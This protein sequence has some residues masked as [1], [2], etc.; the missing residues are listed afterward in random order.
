MKIKRLL[1]GM[2]AC[3]AMVA[4]TNDDVLENNENPLVNKGNSYL[5]VNLSMGNPVSRA[6]ETQGEDFD[7]G[8]KE[9]AAVK[10]NNVIFLFYDADGNYVTEGTIQY[11]SDG[12]TTPAAGSDLVWNVKSDGTNIERTY[13]PVIVLGPTKVAPA[14]VIAILNNNALA[15]ICKEKKL[16]ATQDLVTNTTNYRT[17]AGFVMSNSTYV[18]DNKVVYAADIAP[19]Q[20]CESAADA[21]ANPVDIYVERVAAKITWK[22]ADKVEGQK[23]KNMFLMHSGTATGDYMVNGNLTQL[24]VEIVGVKANAYNETSSLVKKINTGSYFTG[25]NNAGNFRSYW[26]EDKN[27]NGVV[28]A[29]LTEPWEYTGDS[30]TSLKYLTFDGN[31]NKDQNYGDEAALTF[32]VNENTMTEPKVAANDK[33]NA[34]TILVLGRIYV[35]K[36]A[37]TANTTL[38]TYKGGYYTED[39][40][41]DI[42]AGSLTDFATDAEG[43]TPLTAADFTWK[44]TNG[45]YSYNKVDYQTVALKP[46]TLVEG[47]TI[48]KKTTT[49]EGEETT[50]TWTAAT[51]ADVQNACSLETKLYLNGMCYYQIPIKHIYNDDTDADALGEYG[52]VRN[53]SYQLTL[54]KLTN[55]GGA[56]IDEK[57]ELDHIPG[58]DKDYYIAATLNVLAWR[59]VANQNVEL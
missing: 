16:S 54:T 31:E 49:V 32:Y 9:E 29:N 33:T 34:T 26:A 55:I 19:E 36:D 17:E 27:Y 40:Y 50:T 45:K 5:S 6:A 58:Q 39:K 21:I 46:V 1:I 8:T 35:G 13:D 38:F 28:E 4:C 23:E 7:N 41:L 47:K 12:N 25:W 18:K 57:E 37:S 53:H 3:S 30:F 48:Y 10:D 24:R 22:F 51:L 15:N 44:D 59:V 11:Y 2:L 43:K 52:I 14:K 56:V 42:V 20:I